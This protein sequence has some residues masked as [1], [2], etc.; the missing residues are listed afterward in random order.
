MRG[1][2]F[3]LLASLVWGLAPVFIKI[4]LK[5]EVNNLL[6]L[7]VHNLSAFLLASVL[8]MLI[9]GSFVIGSK[10]IVFLVLGGILSGFLGLFFFFEAIRHGNVSIVSPI[11][12]TSPLWSALFAFLILGESLNLQK[13]LGV[14]LII[15]GVVLL[16]LSKT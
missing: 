3:A 15:S 5:S 9:D 14:L 4:G 2:I 10:E 12:S 11:A 1:V 6:A 13:L 8:Y 16:T 7:A